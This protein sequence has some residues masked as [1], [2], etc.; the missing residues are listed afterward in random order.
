MNRGLVLG[1]VFLSSFLA[2]SGMSGPEPSQ[3]VG[4][5]F[6]VTCAQARFYGSPGLQAHF[7]N[8]LPWNESVNVFFAWYNSANQ[9]TSLDAELNILF[10][11][12]QNASFSYANMVTGAY[13]V[14]TFALDLEG[15][16]LSVACGAPVTVP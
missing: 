14:K 2:F 11:P 9:L 16:S 13:Y 8:E 12:G 5:A 6:S 7:T 15:N 1:L 10:A 4:M 3:A